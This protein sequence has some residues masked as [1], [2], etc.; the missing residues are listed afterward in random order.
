MPILQS[1]KYQ[2]NDPN[3]DKEH[4]VLRN[5]LEIIDPIEISHYENK[6][7]FSAYDHTAFDYSDTHCFTSK[8]ICNLHKLF[9]GNIFNWAGHYRQVDISSD[10]IHWCHA[11][12][13]A[14][15]MKKY[16]KRLA[17]LTPFLKK[18]S[19]EEILLR[20]AELHGEL[21]VIHPFRDGNGRTAR[22]LCDLLLMQAKY[23]PIK[24]G[25][26]NDLK[27]RKE[28]FLAIKKILHKMDYQPFVQLLDRLI[29]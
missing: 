23:S 24:L 17:R 21:I 11:L 12:H 29:T 2:T 26:F 19:R 7:L 9:L 16:E 4:N 27:I 5:K 15:E 3:F 8:D 1:N 18:L 25:I 13:I 28:Y 6:A 22:L 20:L 10:E 14:S